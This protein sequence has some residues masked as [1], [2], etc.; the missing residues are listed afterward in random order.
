MRH[1]K[2]LQN[3]IIMKK[4]YSILAI[5]LLGIQINV[6]A[7]DDGGVSIGKG[8]SDA[9]PSAILELVSGSKGLLVP[10]LS[11]AQRE[12]ISSPATGLLVYDTD[13]SSFYYWS[14]VKWKAI[15]GVKSTSGDS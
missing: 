1:K 3:Y 8:N 12:G 15:T 11:Q 10:R 4:F 2:I 6:F 7:Q 13:K 9:D 5:I 14:G